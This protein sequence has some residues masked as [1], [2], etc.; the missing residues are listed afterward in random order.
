M[1]SRGRRLALVVGLTG[2]L[3]A[4][5]GCSSTVSASPKATPSKAAIVMVKPSGIPKATAGAAVV[6]YSGTIASGITAKGKTQNDP[7]ISVAPSA[8][9]PTNLTVTDLVVGTGAVAKPN[10]NISVSYQGV[11]FKTRQVFNDSYPTGQLLTI[12]LQNTIEGW[13][14][15]IPGM[16]VGGVRALVVPPS[17]AYGNKPPDK[18][19]AGPLVFVVELQSIG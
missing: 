7:T 5:T 19:V 8:P 18:S 11:N 13:I 3:A 6:P 2:A 10:S 9:T 14:K 12:G 16:R 4:V 1:S 17:L 15:G